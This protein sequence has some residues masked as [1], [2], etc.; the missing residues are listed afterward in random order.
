SEADTEGALGGRVEAGLER[1]PGPLVGGG[2]GAAAVVLGAADP[3]EAG[4]E[5][6][7]PPILGRPQVLHLL[8][9][10]LLGQEADLVAALAPSLVFRLA[11]FGVCLEEGPG[12]GLEVVEGDLICH[13]P[14]A[15]AT[16]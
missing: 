7:G 5:L 15:T 3:P 6:P 16:V 8:V 10:A 2:E 12:L 4:V 13:R 14:Q 9:V 11:R 1:L